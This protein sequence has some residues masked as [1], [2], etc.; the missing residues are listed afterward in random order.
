M[1]K[2]QEKSYTCRFCGST[3]DNLNACVICEN[4]CMRKEEQ[5]IKEEEKINKEKNI[6]MELENID[7]Q[8]DMLEKDCEEITQEKNSAIQSFNEQYNKIIKKYDSDYIEKHK[9]LMKLKAK[10][11]ELNSKIQSTNTKEIINFTDLL[12]L[13]GI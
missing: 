2:V 9:M 13:F 5:R 6:K 3:Y 11:R 12:D 1:A 7:V 8:I 10:R 4:T